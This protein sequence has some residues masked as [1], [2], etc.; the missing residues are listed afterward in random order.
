MQHRERVRTVS[1]EGRKA[2]ERTKPVHSN[3][4]VARSPPSIFL[5]WWPLCIH[6]WDSQY[7]FVLLKHH[8]LFICLLSWR[9]IIYIH[10]IDDFFMLRRIS[11]RFHISA[12]W[13]WIS[14]SVLFL[15]AIHHRPKMYC[16][17]CC[18]FVQTTQFPFIDPSLDVIGGRRWATSARFRTLRLLASQGFILGYFSKQ[19]VCQYFSDCQV[20]LFL[21]N[22]W[23]FPGSSLPFRPNRG[24]GLHF[25]EMTLSPPSSQ[26]A[27][28]HTVTHIN[29]PIV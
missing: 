18:A 7:Y 25:P 8:N 29:T 10:N 14:W 1:S 4:G 15:V 2:R 11:I 19:I 13:R 21:G 3:G 5:K 28:W 12:F 23:L 27:L 26:C 20:G 16:S 22:S 24:K 6:G 9:L 17:V